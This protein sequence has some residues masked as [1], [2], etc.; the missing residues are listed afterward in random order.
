MASLPSW[1]YT[2]VDFLMFSLRVFLGVLRIL[3]VFF[4]VFSNVLKGVGLT[5]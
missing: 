2:V 3:R 5:D 1:I 4:Y